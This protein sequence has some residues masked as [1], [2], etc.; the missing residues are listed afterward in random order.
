MKDGLFGRI[1]MRCI[2]CIQESPHIRNI[3]PALQIILCNF[4]IIIV[5]TVTEGVNCRDIHTVGKLG[6]RYHTCASTPSIVGV[7]GD[8]FSVSV[9]NGDNITLQVFKEIIERAVVK[10]AADV[11]LVVVEGNEYV[12]TPSLAQ[13]LGAVEGVSMFDTAHRLARADAVCVVGVGVAVVR[14]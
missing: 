11:F 9:N 8:L 10:N 14:L 13:D 7:L 12:V 6:V 1:N 2:I 3:I 5:A 4:G